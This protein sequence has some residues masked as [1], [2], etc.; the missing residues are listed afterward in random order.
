MLIQDF[1]DKQRKAMRLLRNNKI[2][3]LG[4]DVRAMSYKKPNLAQVFKHY[5]CKKGMPFIQKINE[6]ENTLLYNDYYA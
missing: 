5:D 2:H 6:R 1:I 3:L 4:T